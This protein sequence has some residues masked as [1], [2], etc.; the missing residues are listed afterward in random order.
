MVGFKSY[1][2]GI[3]QPL[4]RQAWTEIVQSMK[5]YHVHLVEA[6]MEAKFSSRF[7]SNDKLRK[8][9]QI[10]AEGDHMLKDT[11][12]SI[13]EGSKPDALKQASLFCQLHQANMMSASILL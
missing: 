2:Q 12:C 10:A 3:N 11:F 1:W 13:G 6:S 8:S 9:M 5:T 4:D 7:P